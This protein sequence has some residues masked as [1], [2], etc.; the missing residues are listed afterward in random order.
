MGLNLFVL[1]WGNGLLVFR[2]MYKDCGEIAWLEKVVTWSARFHTWY[3]LALRPPSWHRI[4][5]WV[6]VWVK[7]EVNLVVR[8]VWHFLNSLFS[9]LKNSRLLCICCGSLREP[10]SRLWETL[11]FFKA[12]QLLFECFCSCM[13]R[14]CL[15]VPISETP[16]SERSLYCSPI[17]PGCLWLLHEAMNRVGFLQQR[18]FVVI[19]VITSALWICRQ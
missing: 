2:K 8:V 11:L 1:I 18:R 4:R 13:W 19:F 10:F 15:I 17:V 7:S 9:F 14:S 6:A 16:S 12:Q 3:Q 5:V